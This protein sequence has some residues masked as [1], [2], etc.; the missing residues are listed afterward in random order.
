MISILYFLLF[1][2]F[3]WGIHV[4]I[5]VFENMYLWQVKEY[6]WDRLKAFLKEQKILSIVGFNTIAALILSILGFL[7]ESNITVRWLYLTVILGF[8]YYVYSTL[9][10]LTN[11]FG[12]KFIK[13]KKSPRNF[14]IVFI[15]AL[16]CLYPFVK[17]VN[18]FKQVPI[19][20]DDIEMVTDYS[21]LGEILPKETEEGIV[22]IP[23]DTATV[24]IFFKC[25]F[26]VDLSLPLIVAAAVLL[27]SIFSSA[28]RSY[29]IAKAREKISRIE[30]LKVIGI[31]GSF[32]K[33]TTKEVLHM[34]ISKKFKTYA[35]PRNVNSDIGVANT[36]L[37]N[38]GPYADVFI[39]EMGA[40]KRGE[41][42]AIC[43]IASPDIAIITAVSNQHLA[44]FGS[45]ENILKTKYEIVENSKK[46]A[47]IVLNGDD[48]IVLRIAGKSG[49]SE[50]LY[51]TKKEVDLWASDIKS[52]ED[53]VEFNMHYKGASKRVEVRMLGEHNVS[54]VLAASAVAL[55]LG[56][57][58]SE[59]AGAIKEGSKRKQIGRISVKRSRF[60]YRVIDDSYNSN[61]NGFLAGLEYLDRLKGNKK[62]LV[63][64]G[65][66]ELGE[67][68]DETY[69]ELASKIAE[70]CE[71][72]V[73]TDEKLRYY[74]KQRSK[75]VNIVFDTGIEKQL[76]FLKNEVGGNDVVL[77]EGPNLRLFEE[78]VGK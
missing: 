39:A 40:Y 4:V 26:L 63:T 48:D 6:R 61:A 49:K 9:I 67:K 33:T 57:T 32:G 12:K 62:I 50:L 59:V 38:L 22:M 64:I 78:I 44:L 55:S 41:I 5:R 13:P 42:K 60:G 24:V 10:A 19:S 31:T 69:K 30:N 28:S 54:N 70:V 51:S 65:I 17:A 25:L 2:G 77:F 36:I 20:K 15:V 46:D 58:L 16:F 18:F 3:F 74:V 73:T 71:T 47:L 29:K 66:I 11:I 72:L 27:S 52:K 8:S 7:L 23:V 45:I 35:T 21:D 56:M 14:F 1:V 53:N 68:Q 34:I 37:E 76:H 43:D 75:K